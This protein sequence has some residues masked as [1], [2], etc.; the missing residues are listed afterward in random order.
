M[1]FSV[2]LA[3]S[4]NAIYLIYFTPIRL[5]VSVSSVRAK[6]EK[7]LLMKNWCNLA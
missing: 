2:I 3:P 7:T 5:C 6:T 1:A 4:T